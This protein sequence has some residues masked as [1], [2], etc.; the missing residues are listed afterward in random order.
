MKER[1]HKRIIFAIVLALALAC[2]V[3][4]T[5]K[6]WGAFKSFDESILTE[7]DAQIEKLIKSEDANIQTEMHTFIREA[8]AMFSR[9]GVQEGEET[10][11]NW[12]T[13]DTL[14]QAL[15]SESISV[16]NSPLY[17]GRTVYMGK[18]YEKALSDKGKLKF[19]TDTDAN[20][21]RICMTGDNQ[22]YM[23]YEHKSNKI[24]YY[25]LISLE[26]LLT[27]AVGTDETTDDMAFLEDA[28]RTIIAYK[29]GELVE[30]VPSSISINEDLNQCFN[31][32]TE[33]QAKGKSAATSIDMKATTEDEFA[34]RMIV[35]TVDDT[36]N[37]VFAIG[38]TANYDVAIKPSRAAANEILVF[39]VI[40]VF[41]VALMLMLLV[42]MRRS[43]SAEL[44]E[45]RKRNE[46]MEEINRKM[47][48]LTHHQRLETIGTMTASIAHDF[49][50]LLTPIMG[51]SMMTMEMLPEDAT[52]LQENLMEV[53]N[54]SVKAKDIVSRLAD[55]SKKSDES[56]FEELNPD[57]LVQSTL[58]VTLPVKPKN[59][60]VKVAFNCRRHNIYGNRTQVS[61]MIMNMIINAYDAMRDEGGTL[62]ISTRE[63]DGIV[64]FKFK[65]DGP[66]MSAETVAK[67]FDPFFTTKESG[68]GT[69]LGLA[70]VQQIAVTHDAKIY[71]DSTLGEGTL[72]RIAFKEYKKDK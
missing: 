8:N 15:T 49:N 71:V 14:R 22:Y 35:K 59:V 32:I 10:W 19:L 24:K 16:T 36:K 33:S 21:L 67:I 39:G 37:G 64:N 40:A 1:E 7:K 17:A 48:T 25:L 65:D 62:M 18:K 31:F 54:A 2:I 28:N 46:T 53:Y 61:Q 11:L 51:Y 50:N 26:N 69:G 52:D 13:T 56:S 57:E 9:K 60:E 63:T 30:V 41:G 29:S 12:H 20:N 58:K 66:G 70:I 5:Y 34:A 44:E 42:L 3:V 72:F 27:N 43:T 55:L 38:R 4:G 23:A 45:L 68:K 6:A 47:Q